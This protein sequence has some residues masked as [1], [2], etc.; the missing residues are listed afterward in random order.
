MRHDLNHLVTEDLSCTIKNLSDFLRLLCVSGEDQEL[1]DPG[2][3]LGLKQ[4]YSA[5][6]SLH[7]TYNQSVK[8]HPHVSGIKESHP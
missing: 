1:C 5:A 2:L 4:A 3:A 7:T 6:M 8:D